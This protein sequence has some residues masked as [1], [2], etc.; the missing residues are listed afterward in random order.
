MARRHF[1]YRMAG[2]IAFRASR[3]SGSRACMY[4]RTA[5]LG[6]RHFTLANRTPHT[7]HRRTEPQQARPRAALAVGGGRGVGTVNHKL[8][9]PIQLFYFGRRRPLPP[10]LAK[11][12]V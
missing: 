3:S 1:I 11:R 7:R 10:I 6:S 9:I 2:S 8:E 4:T 5:K 12:L